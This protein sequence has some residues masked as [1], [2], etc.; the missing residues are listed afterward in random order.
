VD[1]NN[2][3]DATWTRWNVYLILFKIIFILSKDFSCIPSLPSQTRIILEVKMARSTST[4]TGPRR[5]DPGPSEP[6]RR[7]RAPSPDDSLLE[8]DEEEDEF[9]N[10]FTDVEHDSDAEDDVAGRKGMGSEGDEEGVGQW[11]PDEWD[12]QSGGSES[13]EEEDT[14]DEKLQM[15]RHDLLGCTSSPIYREN[16]KP[17]YTHQQLDRPSWPMADLTLLPLSTLRKAQKSLVRSTR[18]E[19][20]Q[21]TGSEDSESSEA[22]PSTSKEDRIAQVKARLAEM[23]RRKGKAGGVIDDLDSE[24][25]ARGR[26]ERDEEERKEAARIKRESKNA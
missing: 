15:V 1:W 10:G 11:A 18:P 5:S 26:K 6:S 3:M 7:A 16:Y 2:N 22:G 23:Q 8:T 12:G 20:D 13:D 4:F 9:A 21:D 19:P 17:V 14:R 24:H 25:P